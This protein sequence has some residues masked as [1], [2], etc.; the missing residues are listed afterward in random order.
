MV[1]ELCHHLFFILHSHLFFEI[2][3]LLLVLVQVVD[4]AEDVKLPLV[5]FN[6]PLGKQIY[7]VVVSGQLISL[8]K[9]NS[10]LVQ[11]EQSDFVD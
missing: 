5:V 4:L 6:L 9:L 1:F 11:L 2:T 10:S 7:C 3:G 8:E